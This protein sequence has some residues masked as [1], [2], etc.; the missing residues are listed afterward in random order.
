MT[1]IGEYQNC[2]VS[3]LGKDN[4]MREFL[5]TMVCFLLSNPA[6]SEDRA[7]VLIRQLERNSRG[8]SFSGDLSMVV[9]QKGKERKM[10]VH[11]ISRGTE[12]AL[13]RILEPSRDR[14]TGNL[15][16][17]TDLWQYLPRVNKTIKVPSSLLYQSWMGSDFSNDDLVKA[18]SFERDYKHNYIGEDKLG[19]ITAEKIEST[20]KP[21]AKIVWGK[22]ILWLTPREGALLQ[23]DFYAENGKL[24]KQLKG[25]ELKAFG[26]YHIPT[27]MTMQDFS[28]KESLT[29]ITYSKVEFDKPLKD[30]VFTLKELEKPL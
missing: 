21:E 22:V 20:P 5:F 11:V 9:T 18:S 3:E 13:V 24:I 1:E 16:I 2:E 28:R 25:F 29:E 14:G 6:F 30:E 7:S 27:R 8:V 23:Q 19:D 15:R 17:K 10:S 12:T 26:K 4:L